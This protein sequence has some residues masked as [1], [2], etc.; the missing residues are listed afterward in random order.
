MH[1]FGLDTRKRVAAT[2]AA[3]AALGMV[4]LAT[5]SMSGPASAAVRPGSA[6]PSTARSAAPVAR[7]L[8]DVACRTSKDCM[9]VDG[10]D[11]PTPVAEIW[12]GKAWHSVRVSL[13][14]GTGHGSLDAVACPGGSECVAVGDD[15]P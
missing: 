8:S 5:T 1:H 9:A 6:R 2:A 10:L 7:Y 13:P 15:F 11:S 4:A 14:A 3:L 12:N